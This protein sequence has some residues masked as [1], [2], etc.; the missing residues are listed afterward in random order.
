MSELFSIVDGDVYEI[1]KNL[2]DASGVFYGFFNKLYNKEFPCH[3]I[4]FPFCLFIF[5]P[6]V[7]MARDSAVGHER[8][9]VVPGGLALD[10]SATNQHV[11]GAQKDLNQQILE[12][13]QFDRYYFIYFWQIYYLFCRLK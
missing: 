13:S 4:S 2:V 5:F 10:N 3:F 11:T 8:I 1:R 12:V 9:L 6:P 7:D